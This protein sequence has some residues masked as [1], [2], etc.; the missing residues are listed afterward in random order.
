[1]KRIKPEDVLAAFRELNMKPIQRRFFR[2]GEG[3]RDGCC[4]LSAIGLTTKT[5][6]VDL[7]FLE[8]LNSAGFKD[9]AFEIADTLELDRLYAEGFIEGW[10][11]NYRTPSP[12]EYQDG[13][14]DGEAAR[15]LVYK[16][17]LGG[18]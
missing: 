5:T 15:L 4:A 12:P 11:G 17:L 14:D 18:N 10:D 3:G 13:Y 1:M 8:D 6:A 9:A 7:D 2:N 16:E